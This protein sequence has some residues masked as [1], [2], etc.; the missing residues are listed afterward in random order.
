MGMG[1]ISYSGANA[2]GQTTICL[3]EN[4]TVGELQEIATPLVR[5]AIQ[6]PNQMLEVNYALALMRKY[7]CN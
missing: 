3:P 6:N 4:I 1:I 2:N 5:I 7:P